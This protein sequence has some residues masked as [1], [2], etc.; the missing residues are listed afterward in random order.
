[1]GSQ[2]GSD[3]EGNN[4]PG[5]G[6]MPVNPALV[7]PGKDEPGGTAVMPTTVLDPGRVV[8][9]R[10]NRTE[11]DNTIRDLLGSTAN[12]AMTTPFAADDENEG[13]DTIGESLVMSL[14]LSEQMDQAA[15]KLVAEL[16]ARPAGDVW[17]TKI[18][19]CEP[20]AQDFDACVSQILT[21]FMKNAYR[22]PV[23]AEEVNA[24]VAM[25]KSV[26][27]SGA[28]PLAALAAA[29]KSVLLSPH[30]LYRVE[31]G[32]PDSAVA[33]PLSDY[34]LASRLSYFLWASMPD[35]ALLAAAEAGEL[36]LAGPGLSAQVERMLADPK[37]QGLIESFAGQWLSTRDATSFVPDE[38]AFPDFNDELR[39]SLSQETNLF[40]EALI[41]ENQPLTALL[42][43]DFS[44]VNE[45]LAR[46]YGLPSP[47]GSDAF[48]RVSLN[49]R[50][51]M[52][53][54]T[55]ASMLSTTSY[56]S[57]TS[58]V[59]R[60][61]WV[62]ERLLCESPPPPPAAIPGLKEELPPGLTR[63]QEFEMHRAEPACAGCH[64]IMDPI[65][66]SMENFDATGAYRTM[67]NGGAVDSSGQLADGTPLAGHEDLARAIAED[68]DY[69]ICVAKH[70]L[71]FAVGRSFSG[72]EAKAYAG[73]VGVPMKDATWPEFISA[74]V[75][76][77]A[78]RTR[79]G[80]AQ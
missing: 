46:H 61:E 8:L 70:L 1:M 3:A 18:L 22:R 76:S 13:F 45:R 2:G 52:G 37:S 33:T 16:L 58:P 34:E 5:G 42:L 72:K 57:R 17:R 9:R 32:A 77:E 14:L 10:L 12:L 79:R 21:S 56:P 49:G 71:T 11:Y 40:F 55:Q 29:L 47:A 25:A 36:S 15:S 6:N 35:E 60:A 30:F 51:R 68:A 64:N 65:G 38:T 4:T 28:D 73:G 7:V 48:T 27:E 20:G 50:E 53:V 26:L 74:V 39:L 44:F 78:F 62:L 43:A 54:L 63:R 59:K 66:F 19:S 80:E 69:A 24:R 23:S 67:D 75:Q 31:L 41:T